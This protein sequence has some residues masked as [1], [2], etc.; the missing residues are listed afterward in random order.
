M[1]KTTRGLGSAIGGLDQ[2]LN[3]GMHTDNGICDSISLTDN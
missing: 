3:G 2:Q 1:S